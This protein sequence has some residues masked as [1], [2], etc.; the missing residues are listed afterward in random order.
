MMPVAILHW[1]VDSHDVNPS[2]NAGVTTFLTKVLHSAAVTI[3]SGLAV[4]K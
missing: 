4:P 2:E 3:P 1:P